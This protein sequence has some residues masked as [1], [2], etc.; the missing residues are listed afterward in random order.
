VFFKSPGRRSWRV[1]LVPLAGVLFPL[2]VVGYG[3]PSSASETRE[4]VENGS[5]VA[6]DYKIVALDYKIE[7]IASS[8]GA[9]PVAQAEALAVQAV[10]TPTPGTTRAALPA[11][12]ATVAQTP[13]ATPTTVS[14]GV[15]TAGPS[16]TASVTGTPGTATPTV[17]GTPPTPTPTAS[18]PPAPPVSGMAGDALTALNAERA[19]LGLR[20][21][22]F[23]GQLT[24]AAA[25]YAQYMAQANFFAHDGPDGSSPSSRVSRAGYAGQ[26][27]GETLAAG[28]TSGASVIDVWL[29]SPP[30]RAI[31]LDPNIQEVGIGHFFDAGDTYGHY[32]AL[33]AGIP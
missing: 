24:V 27:R 6:V 26:W 32:W 8:R 4:T 21:V 12:P 25:S 2:L 7:P 14:T 33:E 11:A 9:L 18:P 19:R 10:A 5:V 30:H 1:G 16:A 17:T 28:Q 20:P 13:T 23:N 29:R 15:A 22:T 31:V 3:V